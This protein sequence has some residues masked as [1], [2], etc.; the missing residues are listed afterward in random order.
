MLTSVFLKDVNDFSSYILK[1]TKTG[2][3]HCIF[4]TIFKWICSTFLY[5]L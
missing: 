4:K 2:V 1:Y 3:I 5:A